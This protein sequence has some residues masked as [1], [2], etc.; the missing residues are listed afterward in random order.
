[1]TSKIVIV[2]DEIHIRS[3]IEQSLEDLEDDYGIEIFTAEDGAEGLEI[4]TRERPSLVLLDVMM[5]KMNGYDVCEAI[6]RDPDLCNVFVILL[7]A[8]G[9]EADRERGLR[10]GAA[11]YITKPFDP[12][13]LVERAKAIL[14]LD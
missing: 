3:L 2:D 10:S 12:D 13:E 9:Q 14:G 11:D 1:M 7:T 6:G 5:P 4:V 8:K